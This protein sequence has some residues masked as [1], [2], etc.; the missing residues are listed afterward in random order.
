MAFWHCHIIITVVTIVSE[1]NWIANYWRTVGKSSLSSILTLFAITSSP[2]PSLLI[3]I[4]HHSFLSSDIK[5]PNHPK[6]K[7]THKAALRPAN[8]ATGQGLTLTPVKTQPMEPGT[9]QSL[10]QSVEVQGIRND[11]DS[12]NAGGGSGTDNGGSIDGP[13]V[14]APDSIIG[15]GPAPAPVAAVTAS[16]GLDDKGEKENPESV[17]VQPPPSEQQSQQQ[18]PST[19]LLS[20]Q[21][22]SATDP[23]VASVSTTEP[24]VKLPQQ[25]PPQ[26]QPQ[27]PQQSQPVEEDQGKEPPPPQPL[28]DDHSDADDIL[29]DNSNPEDLQRRTQFAAFHIMLKS[30]RGCQVVV[31]FVPLPS[32]TLYRFPL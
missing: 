4:S 7:A 22:S 23:V 14:V 3:N 1:S 11:S 20:T 19:V 5:S 10:G 16:N 24:V 18:P 8:N 12:M 28:E 15:G 29:D 17:S 6:H 30:S 25:Q 21:P 13:L 2:P 31:D 32:N 9:N 26:Q 27:P